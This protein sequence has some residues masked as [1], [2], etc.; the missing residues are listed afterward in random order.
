MRHFVR[1]DCEIREAKRNG[2][3]RLY[4]IVKPAYN[5]TAKDIMKKGGKFYAI[6]DR[7]TGMWS[8]DEGDVATIID[9]D[10]KEYVKTQC[11]KDESGNY[12]WHDRT[13]DTYL[14]VHML[15]ID[16]S[17]SGQ[18]LEFNRWF[19]NLPPNHNY[20]QLDSDITFKDDAVTPEMYRSKRLSYSISPGDIEAYDRLMSVLYSE[21][22]R[23]KIEWSIG[24]VF[25]G[26]SKK[27][28]KILVLYG[29]PGSGKSTV[30][31]L[32]KELFKGY[33]APF[34]ASELVSKTNQFA[35]AVF[36]DNP[37]IAI[38]DD[39]SLAKIES[40]VINEIISH[41]DVMINEKS[42]QQ[43]AIRSN[44]FLF[45]ATNE[46]VD[47]RDRKLGITRR[48]LDVYPSGKKIPEDEFD[49]IVERLR[50][51]LG[52]IADHCIT[53]FKTL[54]KNYYSR[55]E[56]MKMIEK[57]NPLQNFLFDKLDGLMGRDFYFRDDL[58]KDYKDYF[59]ESGFGYP[60]KRMDFTEQITEYFETYEKSKWIPGKGTVRNVFT[61]LKVNKICGLG[62]SDTVKK[63][64]T[65]LNFDQ[66][67]S[68]LDELYSDQPAQY[69]KDDGTPKNKWSKVKTKL[70]DMDKSKL[71]WVKFPENVIKMDF[72]LTD[73]D[74]NKSLEENVK[75][76]SKFPPT[77]GELSKSGQGIHLY[78]I[79]DGDPSKLEDNYAEHIEIKKS[80]GDRSHR[81]LITK[82]ND[83]QVAHIS[84]GLPLKGE[85]VKVVDE[86]VVI[87]EK[88]LRTTIQKCTHKEV[89]G[90]TRSNVDF[91]YKV[92][93]DA[94]NSG[95]KY[96]VSDM[97][98]EVL[99]FAMNST[100]QSEYCVNKVGEMKFSS[101]ETGRYDDSYDPDGPII[102]F[103]YEVFPN[104]VLLCY[105][106]QGEGN[107]VT[108]IFNPT[109]KQIQDFLGMG[110]KYRNK[111]IGFNNKEYDN[112]ITYAL[113]MGKTPYE[114]FII[115][116]GI[117]NKEKGAKFRE[118]YNLSYSDIRDFCPNKQSL[119]K[120]EIQLNIHHQELGFRWDEPVDEK[121]WPTVASYC[122]NDVIATEAVF[123]A[124]QAAWKGRQ[125]LVDLANILIG[126]GSTVNDST[127]QL[128]TKLIVGNE[129]NPQ[130]YY[131]YPDLAK[132]FPGYEFNKFG[133]DKS[134]Y[135]SKDVIIS[136][137]SIYKGYDPGEGGFVWANHGMYG[138]AISFDSASHHPSSIIAENGFGKFTENFKRL[139][140][141]RLHVKHKEYDVIR[142]MYNGALAKYLQT[143]EDADALSFALK[144]AINSVYG[145]TAA[146]FN[147]PL[148]DPR[149]IDNWVAKRG[150]LFMIDLM[151]NVRAMGYTVLHCK[152]DSIKVLNPDEKVANYIY[153]YGKKFG[154]TFEIEHIF[155]RICLVN[156]AVYVCKY[157]ED[158][159]N[160]KYAGKWDA[161]G[162]QFQVPYVFKT[163]F[164]HEPI[165][166]EDMCETKNVE[167]ALYLDYNE[168][169]PDGEHD[170]QFVGKTG[171]FCPIKPGCG[172]ALLMREKDGKYAAAES[173]KGY[174]WL[175]SEVV[176][177]FEKEDT[178]D[179][180]YYEVMVNKAL[181]KIGEFGSYEKFVSD[182]PIDPPLPDFMNIPETDEEE[183][184]W[185][186]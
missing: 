132:E 52:A 72:D 115:S 94:Y 69:A 13:D 28:E 54:G 101:E 9:N 59:E 19:N 174:R 159:E 148:R 130:R 83:L 169:L 24:S 34:V 92:L 117:I 110:Q 178:I 107:P 162:K 44:A 161:T 79:Y 164:S 133:I 49:S 158:P 16:D 135:I 11:H 124:N 38:Q 165:E 1:I 22:D 138:R 119:K 62:E 57:T 175:E 12:I 45:L 154:Y 177:K 126:P 29:K 35:T 121:D 144:I 166:F 122:E 67:E 10:I 103:D 71:Y 56:P 32:I 25:T 167:T 21:Q 4:L 151:L 180:S 77:Y 82:C 118:A 170:Y 89:H 61:G 86:N 136:G 17:T 53:V 120:W 147:H 128:T 39:G 153:E 42:K 182:E 99:I 70:K 78:Y 106:V 131:N 168:N 48:L 104:L 105:K 152:T 46:V 176:K 65:W 184:P 93:E 90:D 60:P 163:L 157:T 171:Q 137:K 91:I 64:S 80:Y 33:W 111:V 146:T 8:T 40:P 98:Q 27:I 15:L 155:D 127:N 58:Y 55:Y 102:F 26:M 20:V 51:E 160:G 139:L 140:D 95:L 149:N 7:N 134:R 150:A 129:K 37:L 142:S 73:K 186:L 156:D 96:D 5:I 109:P 113:L 23:E 116:Q 143:D 85:E 50:F 84:T 3:K 145:L 114:V 66:T 123:N 108:K 18:L 181:D 185:A 141:L 74:G 31:D 68:I 87:T 183:L 14:P 6:L 179:T 112:H 172:G 75:A 100:H 97:R 76:A 41:K 36:K 81:R 43:Y 88:G 47:I 2:K 63:S 173:T 125:I 30:L